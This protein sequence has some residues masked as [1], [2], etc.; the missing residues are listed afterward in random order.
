MNMTLK[1]K[2]VKLFTRQN[3]IFWYCPECEHKNNEGSNAGISIHLN[4]LFDVTCEHCGEVFSASS[5]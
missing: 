3:S 1:Q 4:Y 5:N 2:T